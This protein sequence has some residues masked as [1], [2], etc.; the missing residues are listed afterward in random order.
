MIYDT[1]YY[2]TCVLSYYYRRA[3][4]GTMHVLISY[5]ASNNTL[6]LSKIEERK[7]RSLIT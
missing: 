7:D 2:S 1:V 5:I 6:T 3:M 4:Q